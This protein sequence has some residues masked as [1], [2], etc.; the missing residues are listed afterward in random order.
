MSVRQRADTVVGVACCSWARTDWAG[1]VGSDVGSVGT[2]APTVFQLGAE[3]VFVSVS[4]AKIGINICT[5]VYR[6]GW[7]Y[8]V[9]EIGI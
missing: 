2:F 4:A 9:L 6:V 1:I 5:G 7:G 3:V 8:R